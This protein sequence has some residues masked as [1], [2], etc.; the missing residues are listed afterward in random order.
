[1][2]TVRPILS[3]ILVTLWISFSEFFRNDLLVKSLWTEHYEVI[4]LTFPGAPAN[5]AV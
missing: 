2:K 4:G 1:M 3:V 5:G